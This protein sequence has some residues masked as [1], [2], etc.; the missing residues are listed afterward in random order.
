MPRVARIVLPGLPHHIVQRGNNRQDVF[1]VDDDYRVYL[2]MLRELA[3]RH[4]LSIQG[5]CL[6]TNHVH[7]IATP[8]SPEALAKAV[9]RTNFRYAM[10]VNRLHQR[11]GHLWQNR[12]FSCAL[13]EV[14]AWRALR[15]VERNPVRARL[16]R[17]AWRYW[18][19]SAAEHCGC[20]R[21]NKIA[22]VD[23]RAWQRTWD[24]GRWQQ[25]LRETD[26]EETLSRLRL[27]TH[28]GRPLADDSFLSKLEHKLGR[29]LRPLPVGRP[30]RTKP[31]EHPPPARRSGRRRN[32]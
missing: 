20:R 28:R 11:S 2:E 30:R 25:T 8:P 19:S 31:G 6:M 3:E 9:G 4:R 10:Y 21:A 14:H 26:D 17:V 12:F 24:A 13:D 16:V 22:L 23:P 32:Q 1:F 29:R 15:Y 7:L 5:Y 27:C 18:W